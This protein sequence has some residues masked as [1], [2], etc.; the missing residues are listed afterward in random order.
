MGFS[1]NIN[2]GGENIPQYVEK[3][4]GNNWFY[5]LWGSVANRNQL[6]TDQ[7][8]LKAIL[9]NPALLKCISLNADIGSL[10]IINK[11]N[12]KQIEVENFLKTIVD[13]PNFKQNWTQFIWDYYFWLSIG[14]A[15]LYN[16]YNAKLLKESNPIQWLN[17][18]NIN[19]N[20]SVLNK[21]KG[22]FT[23]KESFSKIMKSEIS[24]NVGDGTQIFMSLEEVVPFFDLTNGI[25][26]NFYKGSSRIDALYK[27]IHNSE[28][29]LD[30]QSINLEFIQKFLVSGQQDPE[31][32][33]QLPMG[34]EEKRSIEEQVRSNKKVHAVKSKISIERFVQDY[35]K[36][37][38]G[39][40]YSDQ[41]LIIGNMFNIP[42]EILNPDPT[43]STYEN[44]EKATGRHIE[45]AIKPKG[46]MLTDWFESQYNFSGLAQGWEH[47]S[48][49]QVFEVDRQAVITAKLN[50]IK[51]AKELDVKIEDL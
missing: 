51:L 10:G 41:Y 42:L 44:Q 5:S 2:W 37:K 31:N 17:P 25:D 21:M 24:Y 19:W 14:T 4:A 45:Y 39:E 18:V 16:P 15:Y 36:M 32:V 26:S 40:A 50:N 3:D 43:G 6:T 1:F 35:G 12:G 33:S 7:A 13:K 34:E 11:Y 27:V 49:N 22:I 48:F 46:Q 23:S 38:L 30:A 8:K 29:A 20:T 9:T 47:L 28:L